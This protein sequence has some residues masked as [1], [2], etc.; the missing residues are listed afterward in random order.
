ML[1]VALD[2]PFLIVCRLWSGNDKVGH[3]PLHLVLIPVQ[4]AIAKHSLFLEPTS[5]YPVSHVKRHTVENGKPSLS[6]IIFPFFGLG[7]AGHV[8][9]EIKIYEIKEF[10]ILGEYRR[11]N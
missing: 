9:T 1:P 7:N 2:C 10:S 8:F 4:A 11:I 6:Q 5:L 3:I